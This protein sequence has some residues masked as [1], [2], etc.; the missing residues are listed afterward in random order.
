MLFGCLHFNLIHYNDQIIYARGLRIMHRQPS[1]RINTTW[2]YKPTSGSFDVEYIDQSEFVAS[3]D[4]LYHE[5][6]ASLQRSMASG[7]AKESKVSKPSLFSCFTLNKPKASAEVKDSKMV[8]PALVGSLKFKFSS[9]PHLSVVVD[10]PPSLQD[11][12]TLSA[13]LP[14]QIFS[15]SLSIM[16]I[17]SEKLLFI[18]ENGERQVK[19]EFVDKSKIFAKLIRHVKQLA[20]GH[21]ECTGLLT[22]ENDRDRAKSLL[23]DLNVIVGGLNLQNLDERF[24]QGATAMLNKTVD[25]LAE[26][27]E[28]FQKLK[29][30][31]ARQAPPG[32][33]TLR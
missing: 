23:T 19:F 28:V 16:P 29:A 32:G 7:E 9:R 14:A 24:L 5:F 12:L 26:E 20:S 15:V 30:S 2:T 33:I 10:N 21:E 1:A 22:L 6:D 11:G 31:S 8:E 17:N 13:A 3:L 27:V 4:I 18:I 25:R